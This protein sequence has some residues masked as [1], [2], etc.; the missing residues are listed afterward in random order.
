LSAKQKHLFVSWEQQSKSKFDQFA[1]LAQMASLVFFG[2]VSALVVVRNVH[3]WVEGKVAE[4]SS[5]R[6]E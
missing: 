1:E 3:A 2:Q 4:T 5:T 6:D